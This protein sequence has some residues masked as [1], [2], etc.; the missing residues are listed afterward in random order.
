MFKVNIEAIE[1]AGLRDD[2]IIMVG[3]APV[4]QEYADVVG[5][6]GYAADAASATK[7]AK[8]L[9]EQ[10]RALARS[11]RRPDGRRHR[12]RARGQEAGLRLPDVRPVRPARHGHDLPDDVPEDAA[13]RA[14]R[15][16]ARGRPLRG[17]AGD[18]LRLGEGRGA[19]AD[20][21]APAAPVAGA[22]PRAPPAGRQPARRHLVV[23]QPARAA[24][25]RSG[26]RAGSRARRRRP[27]ERASRARR[28][29]ATASILTGEAPAIDGGTLDVFTER[30]A[31]MAQWVDAMN[32]TDNTAAHA[33][34]SNVACAIAIAQAGV[35]PILQV[36]CR[37]KNRI[38]CQAD[39]VG[40]ALHGVEN[41]CCLTG[42]DVTAG[43]EPEARRVFDLDGPQ[44]ISVA[45]GSRRRALPLGPEAR[46]GA[47]ALR[48]RGREPGRAAARPPR[49]AG[50]EEDRGRGAL[51]AAPD[52]LSPRP[53]RGVRR[54][55]STRRG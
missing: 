44:L 15:R 51:P 39:I 20:P 5:A 36:V 45:T 43:D 54:R 9:L 25:T 50:R 32:A 35:E 1:K 46:P 23:G 34:A 42:D 31:E 11:E 16:R 27:H 28:D 52:L 38:A 12:H 3:G 47:A 55:R 21:A 33:H 6:D 40:A 19:V 17:E 41:V 26:R 30:I 4:T 24:A 7:R 13:E 14:V 10:R 29:A 2:V 48:R 22:L 53:A 8:E 49:P 18:A 37:D